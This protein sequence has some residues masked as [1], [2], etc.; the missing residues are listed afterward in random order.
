MGLL[1]DISLS[2]I[3]DNKAILSCRAESGPAFLR[4]EHLE[5]IREALASELGFTPELEFVRSAD[6]AA[7][8]ERKPAEPDSSELFRMGR[9][10]PLVKAVLEVFEQ[11]RVTDVRVDR[12]AAESAREPEDSAQEQLS[13]KADTDSDVGE[14]AADWSADEPDSEEDD[15]RN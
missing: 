8:K 13:G 1:R 3:E 5:V 14:E 12:E 10:L 11:A 4:P 9:E 15:H 2:R 7:K 6:A